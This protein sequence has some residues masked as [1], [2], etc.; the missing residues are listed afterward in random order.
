[1][2]ENFVVSPFSIWSLMLLV[3]EGA[4]DESSIQLKNVLHLNDLNRLGTS[5]RKLRERLLSNTTTV[6]LSLNQA[7]FSDK[8]AAIN[9]SFTAVL[10]SEYHANHEIVNFRETDNAANAI[11]NFI[12]TQTQGKIGNIVSAQDL[13]NTHLLLTSSIYFNGQWKVSYSFNSFQRIYFD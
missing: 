9:N 6:G 1:M 12:R 4:T 13:F 8:I 7:L 11:N 3:A 10:S 2:K 5:Y